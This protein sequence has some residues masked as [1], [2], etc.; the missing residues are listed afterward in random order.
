MIE[1]CGEC[2]GDGCTNCHYK[3]NVD[4]GP[5]EVGVWVNDDEEANYSRC[6][7]AKCQR[8]NSQ[9]RA[10]SYISRHARASDNWC[11]HLLREEVGADGE[12]YHVY[13]A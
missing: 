9:D 5:V 2:Y 4:L 13:L 10:R 11:K 8:A 3:G 7:V 1:V 6:P 12:L